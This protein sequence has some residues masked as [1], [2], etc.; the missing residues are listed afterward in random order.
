LPV[1][2][3]AATLGSLLASTDKQ[4]NNTITE[5][6]T[7]LIALLFKAPSFP[8]SRKTTFKKPIPPG[9]RELPGCGKN[10]QLIPVTQPGTSS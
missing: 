3:A 7:A 10:L 5:I 8:A 1:S 2:P 6:A 4:N 9:E